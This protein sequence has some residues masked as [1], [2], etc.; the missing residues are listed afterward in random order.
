MSDFVVV[1]RRGVFLIVVNSKNLV[2]GVVRRC[3]QRDEEDGGGKFLRSSC[4][5]RRPE[6]HPNLTVL[7]PRGVL[8]QG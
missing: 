3:G 1:S 8:G 2:H 6:S 5:P 7:S 4:G